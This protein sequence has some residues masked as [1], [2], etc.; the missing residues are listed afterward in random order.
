[1]NKKLTIALVAHDRRK[2][3]MIEW[4]IH[5]AQFLSGHNMVCTG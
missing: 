2:V 5:N 1:M 3:D 4:A